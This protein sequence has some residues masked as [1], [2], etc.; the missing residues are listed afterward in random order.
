[1]ITWSFY[2][3]SDGALTGRR[4][5]GQPQGLAANTPAGCGAVEGAFDPINQAVD[6][7]RTEVVDFKPP[8]P[9][10]TALATYA[11]DDATRRW[12]A[13]PTLAARKLDRAAQVQLLIDRQEAAQPRAMRD[14]VLALATAQAV[15]AASRTRL[16][17]INTEVTLQRARL[18]AIAAAATQAELDAIP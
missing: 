11:W 17:E 2:R 14:V 13:T 16:N 4:F 1:M 12:L 15:P 3:L 18:Q 6:L 7:N 5:I 10:D 9:S 8:A